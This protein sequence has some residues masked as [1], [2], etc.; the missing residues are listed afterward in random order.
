[1]LCFL[2]GAVV[3]SQVHLAPQHRV[4]ERP[5]SGSSVVLSEKACVGNGVA[6]G[7]ACFRFKGFSSSQVNIKQ[8]VEQLAKQGDQI[9]VGRGN[10][11]NAIGVLFEPNQWI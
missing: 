3:Q 2:V 11:S 8:S 6:C 1:M 4:V 9:G 10:R 7:G 5:S